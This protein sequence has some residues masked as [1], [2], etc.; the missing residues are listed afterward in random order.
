[1]SDREHV[2]R[3]FLDAVDAEHRV[4][5]VVHERADAARAKAEGDCGKV[6]VLADVP[7][8]QQ[9]VSIAAVLVFRPHA[10]EDVGEEEH[11]AA[12]A[13]ELLPERL[14]D[15]VRAEVAGADLLELMLADG[16][17][18]DAEPDAV[19]VVDDDVRLDRLQG[20]G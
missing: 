6:G 10:L 13:Q 15:R 19:D 8:F 9:P 11:G 5:L 4:D 12:L 18:V 2:H 20:A 17:V 1:V 3:R 7:S 14:V 16:V